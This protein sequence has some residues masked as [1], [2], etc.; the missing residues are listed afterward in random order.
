MVV[1]SWGL[2][3][4]RYKAGDN[5]RKPPLKLDALLR[6]SVLADLFEIARMGT[7]ANLALFKK[8]FI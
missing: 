5:P 7:G 4:L 6:V 3:V 8:R 1:L 2:Q